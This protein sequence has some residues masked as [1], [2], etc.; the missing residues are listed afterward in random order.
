MLSITPLAPGPTPL[1]GNGIV[2]GTRGP[3]RGYT[4]CVHGGEPGEESSDGAPG[5][6]DRCRVRDLHGAV[7]SGLCPGARRGRELGARGGAG[8]IRAPGAGTPAGGA[9]HAEPV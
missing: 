4:L 1:S 7:D 9:T 3:V 5:S 2:P 8:A 6:D